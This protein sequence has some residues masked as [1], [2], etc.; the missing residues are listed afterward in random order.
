MACSEDGVNIFVPLQD[1]SIFV[2]DSRTGAIL[3]RLKCHADRVTSVQFAARECELFSSSL[4]GFLVRWK[5]KNTSA[6]P[7]TMN[8]NSENGRDW[9]S[10]EEEEDEDIGVGMYRNVRARR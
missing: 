2:Y 3:E 5:S 7:R 8:A 10:D 4:D 1:G 9:V 6:M